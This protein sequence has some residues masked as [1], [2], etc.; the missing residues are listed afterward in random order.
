MTDV[1]EPWDRPSIG[2][3]ALARMVRFYQLA[4]EGRPSPCRH[5]PSCSTYAVE[6]I[7]RHGAVR[8]AWLTTRRLSRCHPWGTEGHD[9]VPER[10]G[11]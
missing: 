3:K 8:G 7:E 10:K 9:P 11:A 1:T 5:V 6:A 4:T 2:A